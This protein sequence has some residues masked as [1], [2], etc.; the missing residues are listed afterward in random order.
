[1]SPGPSAPLSCPPRHR[2]GVGQSPKCSGTGWLSGC[3]GPLW[4][5]GLSTRR[6]MHHPE[7]CLGERE[8]CLGAGNPLAGTRPHPKD[9]MSTLASYSHL[10]QICY[11]L[12][13][14]LP[15]HHRA[16]LL[17]LGFSSMYS[18]RGFERPLQ[19]DCLQWIFGYTRW[20]S[21][22]TRT[23]PRALLLVNTVQ[24]HDLSWPPLRTG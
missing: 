8:P 12:R 9:G 20:D 3:G 19:H 21:V 2:L 16:S 7:K 17:I 23:S 22:Q 24:I 15:W 18:G 11:K 4:V 6:S 10:A 1:M 14:H 13:E 5:P